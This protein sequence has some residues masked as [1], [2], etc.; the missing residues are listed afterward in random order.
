MAYSSD[1]DFV[2]H[3]LRSSDWIGVV[4]NSNDPTFSGRC[5]VKVFGLFD[6][7]Q[8]EHLPWA[9]P[10]NSTIFAGNGAGSISIPKPGHFVD[11]KST[12]LNSSH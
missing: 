2:Q 6:G 4:I 1:I 12:R 3:D 5:Q 10:I 11:R 7:I 9:T 8:N